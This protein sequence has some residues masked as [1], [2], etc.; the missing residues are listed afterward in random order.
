MRRENK[1]ALI[2]GFSVLL[3]VA[4]LV[5]D[6][7][8]T[9][10]QQDVADSFATL[11]V[12]MISA[13]GLI[14]VILAALFSSYVQPLYVMTAVPFAVIGMIWGHFFLGFDLTILSDRKSTRLNSSH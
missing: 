10:R 6:H 7:L 14:Y 12:A 9:A 8:S 1:L 5:S 13:A 11:P 4:V 2:V 3:V